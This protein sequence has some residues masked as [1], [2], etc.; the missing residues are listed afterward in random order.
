MGTQASQQTAGSSARPFLRSSSPRDA[1]G[2]NG[3]EPFQWLVRAGF[4]ARGIIYAVI[5]TLTFALALGI[6]IKPAAANPQGALT[7]IGG[8]PL[9]RLALGII[10]VSVLAYAIWKLWQAV[11]GHG[12]EGG[13]GARVRDRL[14]N[15]GGSLVYLAFFGVAIAVFSGSAGNGSEEPKETASQLLG[16]PGG[17]LL[18]G[19]A[20][21]VLLAVSVYQAYDAISGSFAKDSKTGQMSHRRR[22]VFMVIGRVGIVARAIIF[23]LVGY[24]LLR[25]AI[26]LH[27]RL[28]VG[29]DGAL[30]RVHREP[31]GSWLLGLVAAGLLIFA[32]FSV[33]EGH[34]RRL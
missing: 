8:A 1:R 25:A 18:L 3:S 6:G 29:V 20:G 28:A 12:P 7:V 27:A 19:I 30:A 24:F 11:R 34:H 31:F 5:A 33:L 9:G 21:T 26:E 17:E 32:A 13:G 16:M 15:L 22:R 2:I 10:A 23:S 4:F 14:A